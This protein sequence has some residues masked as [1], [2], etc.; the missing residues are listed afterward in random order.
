ML[1]KITGILFLIIGSY[2]VTYTLYRLSI[3]PHLWLIIKKLFSGCFGTFTFI[4]IL[5]NGGYLFI[6]Y[7]LIK[8]GFKW[9]N[10]LEN[11]NLKLN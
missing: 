7:L 11:N 6:I 4:L 5:F 9:T 8:Y 10:L 3:N 2:L 1:K